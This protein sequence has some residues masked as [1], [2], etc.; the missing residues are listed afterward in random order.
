MD[1]IRLIENGRYTLDE[2]SKEGRAII[3]GM[4]EII[5]EVEDYEPDE[6]EI[7]GNG[8]EGVIGKMVQEIQS[9][10]LSELEERLY[11][12][13][14]EAIVSLIEEEAKGGSNE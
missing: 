2:L 11:S 4:D 12:K 10:T 8:T 9:G 13:R 14:C 1:F 5:K 7:L 6:I 3:E